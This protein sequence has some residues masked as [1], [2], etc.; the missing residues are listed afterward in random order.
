MKYDEFKEMCN[1]AW[2]ERF[3]Y[4]FID[5][6]KIK[7]KVNIVFS[8]KAK[9]LTLNVFVKLKLF[10]SF[11]CCFQFPIKDRKDLEKLNEA[12]SSQNQVKVV[13][14]QHNLS[15]QNFHEDME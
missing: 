7:M 5:M 1:K 3:N 10:K 6:T 8:T 13:R 12:V 11:E 14:L 2:S 4:L 9:T 15:K